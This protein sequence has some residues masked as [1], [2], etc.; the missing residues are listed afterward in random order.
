MN[1]VCLAKRWHHH[2][3][4][5]GYDCLAKELGATVLQRPD[6]TGLLYRVVRKLWYMRSRHDA[7]LLDY[8]YEDMLAER[9]LLARCQLERPDVAHVLYGDEQLDFLLQARPLLPCPLVASFHLPTRRV[10]NRFEYHQKHLLTRLDAAIVVS[11]CQLPDFQR[12]LGS[13]KVFYVP[14]GIDTSRF[15]PVERDQRRNKIRLV[16][17]GE[18][19]RDWEAWRKIVDQCAGQRLP[20][21]IDVVVKRSRWQ[22]F[23]GCTDVRL[24]ASLPEEQLISLYQQADALLVPVLDATANNSVL[25]SLAC[26]TPA[27]SNSV[28]GITDYVDETCGWLFQKGDVSGPIDLITGLCRNPEVAWSRRESARRKSL[29]FSWNRVAEQMVGVYQNLSVRGAP[30]KSGY[31]GSVLPSGKNCHVADESK[32]F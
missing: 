2:T 16:M 31:A 14:H 29:E 18:H 23:A 22:M 21:Q 5:G 1:V 25:E 30:A 13:A 3:P 32:V 8:Q 6:K 9:M 26:G 11:R 19:M 20:V 7:Y 4:S 17:V 28:G 12:W 10:A 27:I 15:C 24:H